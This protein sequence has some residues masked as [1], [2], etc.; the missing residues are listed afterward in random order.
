VAADQGGGRVGPVIYSGGSPM[1]SCGWG[2]SIKPAAVV[3]QG[4]DTHRAA[5]TRPPASVPGP[6]RHAAALVA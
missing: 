6:G 2:G 1:V 5:L 3:Q 4:H